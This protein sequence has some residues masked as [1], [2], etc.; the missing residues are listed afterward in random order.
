MRFVGR[1]IAPADASR[2]IKKVAKIILKA[3]CGSGVVRELFNKLEA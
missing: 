3:K 2:E 1:P